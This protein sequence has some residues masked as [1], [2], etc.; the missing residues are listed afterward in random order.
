MFSMTRNIAVLACGLFLASSAVAANHTYPG[1]MCVKANYIADNKGTPK[2]SDKAQLL[3]TSA[4]NELTV[5]CPIVGPYNDLSGT[6]PDN[7][8]EVFVHDQHSTKDICCSA[9]LNNVGAVRFGAEV[10]S[11]NTDG[12]YQTLQM[13]T[14]SFNFSFTSRYFLCTI[15]ETLLDNPSLIHLYRH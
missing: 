15:P 6:P 4:G 5:V 14:P 13:T 3:N 12:R 2:V 1:S 8:A 9:R 11:S 7:K 10:C